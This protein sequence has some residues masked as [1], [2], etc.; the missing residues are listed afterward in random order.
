MCKICCLEAVSGRELDP[1]FKKIQTINLKLSEFFKPNSPLENFSENLLN[2]G[3]DINPLK[4]ELNPICAMLALLG[5][6]HILHVSR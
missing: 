6:N 2:L 3:K 1:N 5:A 4:A